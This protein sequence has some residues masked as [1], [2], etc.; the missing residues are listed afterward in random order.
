MSSNDSK[1]RY[2][3][4][5]LTVEVECARPVLVDLLDDVVEVVVGEAGVD[6][7]QDLL[8]HVRRDVPVA[9]PIVDSE[10]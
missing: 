5:A 9:L 7:L 6:L 4:A 3:E 2:T 10:R 1:T 8:Q